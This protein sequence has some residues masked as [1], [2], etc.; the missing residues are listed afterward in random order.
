MNKRMKILFVC[1]ANIQRSRTGEELYRNDPR[2]EVKSAG[3][4]A[5]ADGPVDSELLG[6]AE[7]IVVMEDHHRKE[8]KQ[9]YPRI[10]KGKPVLC[11]DIPDIY[12]FMEPALVREIGHRFEKALNGIMRDG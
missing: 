11:L 3:T 6:W 1:T 9:R 5:F 7:C 8:I 12:T 4:S 10:I 2:F